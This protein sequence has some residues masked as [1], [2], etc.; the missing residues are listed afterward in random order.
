MADIS[1]RVWI[2]VLGFW[3]FGNLALAMRDEACDA[4]VVSRVNR[5]FEMPTKSGS[6][7]KLTMQ[8]HATSL[9]CLQ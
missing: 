8:Y 3:P 2:L 4:H 1:G 9:P 5:R 7:L 6:Y